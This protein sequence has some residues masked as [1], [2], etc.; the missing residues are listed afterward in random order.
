MV[1]YKCGLKFEAS[2]IRA[3]NKHNP[4]VNIIII[5]DRIFIFTI[6][7]QLLQVDIAAHLLEGKGTMHYLKIV[8]V[9]FVIIFAL[10]IIL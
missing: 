7:E 8:Q 1:S 10:V 2:S 4:A 3:L 5:F 6:S 9:L